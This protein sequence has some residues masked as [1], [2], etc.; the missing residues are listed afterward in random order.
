MRDP[1]LLSHLAR[2]RLP[3]SR[4]SVRKALAP[5]EKASGRSYSV[6][7]RTPTPDF[8][9]AFDID[10]VVL[11]SAAPI[12]GASQTLRYLQSNAIPFIF[13]TNGGGKHE[14]ARI[15]DLSSKLSLQLD[16]SMIVQSHTP[17]ARLVHPS[18]AH[19][20]GLKDKCVLVL[21]GDG[22]ACRD[23]A[24]QYGFTNVVTPGDII[25]AHPEI[26]PFSHV[27]KDYYKTFAQPLPRPINPN[28]PEDSLK[29]DAIFVYADPRDWALDIQI[30]LDVLLSTKG[31]LGTYSSMNSDSAHT[32]KGY[33]Q[34][35]QPPIYF[36]N[37][38]LLWAAAYHLSRLGQ[39]GFREA[40]DGVWAAITGGPKEGVELKKTV[41]GK[42]YRETYEFAENRLLSHR[43]YLFGKHASSQKQ[44]LKRVY[45][46][47]DNPESDI[48]G[49]ND[50]Q[51]P[52]GV[53]WISLLTRTGVYR[54]REGHKPT[55][56][57]T[58]IVD[59][60][61]SAVQWALDDSGWDRT[62]R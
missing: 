16:E 52:N 43:E 60:V 26:S 48:K 44:L 5:Q 53:E 24:H 19:P 2:C 13:L 21:G 14:S 35:S 41:I 50:F 22:N 28:S 31:I 30:V 9:F 3:V 17:F 62:I 25:S 51:S 7:R 36:S 54:D 40:L 33:Q 39:G 55:W 46:V 38:D 32:N 23:V 58:A 49:A 20:F 27:F 59:D 47:G 10:G 61:K 6:D 18:D 56:Q 42:P 57:P 45:M 12:P 8:A 15:A 1:G 11:R 29:I 4:V 37:P 34:D